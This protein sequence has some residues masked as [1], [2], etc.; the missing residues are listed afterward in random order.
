MN[1][2]RWSF[3]RQ[4]RRLSCRRRGIFPGGRLLCK[5]RATMRTGMIPRA[6][7][8]MMENDANLPFV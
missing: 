3:L 1:L 2:S 6:I 8:V 4:S 5:S 7:G